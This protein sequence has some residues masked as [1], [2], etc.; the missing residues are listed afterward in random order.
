[1]PKETLDMFHKR[2][3]INTIGISK[4]IIPNVII[5][6][7]IK[8]PIISILSIT[9]QLRFVFSYKTVLIL[10][11]MNLI[12]L[13]ITNPIIKPN[14]PNKN[15]E[16]TIKYVELLMQAIINKEIEIRRKYNKIL[17]EIQNELEKNQN[18]KKF[19]Y[20]LPNISEIMN[21]DRMDSSLYSEDFRKKEFLITNYKYGVSS[22]KE[23][24]F[25]ISRGQ[26]LQISNIGKSIQT[27]VYRENYNSFRIHR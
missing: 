6:N 22:V 26:N 20:D 14:I 19:K 5:A 21:L 8:C 24:G 15:T 1:M 23:L 10:L 25:Q 4:H 17:D 11:K 13:E 27:D 7:N 16:D 18:N 3:P 2:T 9:K 12:K